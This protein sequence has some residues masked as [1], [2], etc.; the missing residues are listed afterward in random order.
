MYAA[1]IKSLS[2]LCDNPPLT[3]LKHT[4]ATQVDYRHTCRVEKPHSQSCKCRKL[5]L[6]LQY[7]APW[8]RDHQR[9]ALAHLFNC[10][11]DL[12]QKRSQMLHAT[13]WLIMMYYRNKF[14]YKKFSIS[15]D[16][17][18]SLFF[19]RCDHHRDLDFEDSNQ[20]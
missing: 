19:S 18:L 13:V 20:N 6:G 9:K 12:I 10:D 16:T 11:L 17:G 5:G 15:K 2:S 7:L 4:A 1:D 8:L 14:G 3:G